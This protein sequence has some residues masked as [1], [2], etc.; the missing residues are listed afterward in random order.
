MTVANVFDVMD[1]ALA[2][3]VVVGLIF[4]FI[5]VS[6]MKGSEAYGAA[7]Y[8]TTLF[9]MI[10][11]L[12]LTAAVNCFFLA[13]DTVSNTLLTVLAGVL[14]A[15]LVSVVTGSLADLGVGRGNNLYKGFKMVL[16][17]GFPLLLTFTLL[18]DLGNLFFLLLLGLAFGAALIWI[19]INGYHFFLKPRLFV[20]YFLTVIGAVGAYAA[21]FY[22]TDELCAAPQY[23]TR[24]ALSVLCGTVSVLCAVNFHSLYN[25]AHVTYGD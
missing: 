10:L 20:W 21:N 5:L 6:Y 12:L 18:L 3:S 8:N 24:S 11:A 2:G 23:V 7:E 15:V 14:G 25:A 9:A 19:V 1:P 4:A 16:L 22:L 13:N 17:I